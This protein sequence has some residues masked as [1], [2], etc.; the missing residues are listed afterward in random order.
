MNTITSTPGP[1]RDE[2]GRNWKN[3]KASDREREEKLERLLSGRIYCSNCE[4]GT[5]DKAQAYANIGVPTHQH[6]WFNIIQWYQQEVHGKLST[7]HNI[8]GNSQYTW[9][10]VWI[11]C[12][13]CD[14]DGK[15]DVRP[16]PFMWSSNSQRSDK[17]FDVKPISDDP[18]PLS[19]SG[20]GS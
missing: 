10:S 8:A 1:S 7:S 2:T 3:L 15:I 9:L 19:S 11:R 5:P 12:S 18:W 13:V 6:H 14:H 16:D 20:S 4:C 17:I